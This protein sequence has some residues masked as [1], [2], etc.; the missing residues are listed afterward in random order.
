MRSTV[1]AFEENLSSIATIIEPINENPIVLQSRKQISY[2]TF[3][4]LFSCYSLF[5][6]MNFVLLISYLV[7][8]RE[9]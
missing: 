2:C 7:Y 5:S 4:N 3:N 9:K 8:A 6:F 1:T